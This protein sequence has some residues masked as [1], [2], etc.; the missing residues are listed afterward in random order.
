MRIR[1]RKCHMRRERFR[2]AYEWVSPRW[3]QRAVHQVY[4]SLSRIFSHGYLYP[5]IHFSV[6]CHDESAHASEGNAAPQQRQVLLGFCYSMQ[7]P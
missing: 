3:S 5:V 2:A 6:L 1:P 4:K 7:C